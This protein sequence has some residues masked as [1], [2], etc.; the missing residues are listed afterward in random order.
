M[1]DSLMWLR[2]CHGAQHLRDLADQIGG[3]PAAVGLVADYENRRAGVTLCA[4]AA[5]RIKPRLAARGGR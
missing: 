2:L 1:H 4:A 5:H 3:W